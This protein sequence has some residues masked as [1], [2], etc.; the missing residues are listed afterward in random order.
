MSQ[1]TGGSER[2][3]TRSRPKVGHAGAGA[4]LTRQVAG[5]RLRADRAARGLRIETEGDGSTP[6]SV[7]NFSRA[8]S[9]ALAALLVASTACR[10]EP[11]AG[12]LSR[13]KFVAAN[14]AL[15]SIP[16]STDQADSL[17]QAVLR[18]H[19]VGRPE[20]RGFVAAHSNDP[21]LMASV[22]KEI[23]DSLEARTKRQMEAEAKWKP[24]EADVG[25]PPP[26]IE[27]TLPLP[28]GEVPPAKLPPKGGEEGLPGK[29]D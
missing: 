4:V 10:T 21:E 24:G 22:W 20:L 3:A 28:L 26:P 29:P 16:D 17:R 9:A 27:R 11:A 13:E 8:I 23:A 6:L 2:L 25:P 5:H 1:A 14:L 7:M 19:R 12:A 18:K 15:R